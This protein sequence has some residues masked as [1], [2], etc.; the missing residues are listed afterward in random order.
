MTTK[1]KKLPQ[2]STAFIST[3]VPKLKKPKSVAISQPLFPKASNFPKQIPPSL[4][5]KENIRHD[6]QTAQYSLEL[7]SKAKTI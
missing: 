4:R 5:Q 7:M 1:H 2:S 3:G 6:L